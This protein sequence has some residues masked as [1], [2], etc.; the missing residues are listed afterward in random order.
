MPYEETPTIPQW[1]DALALPPSFEEYLSEKEKQKQE[2]GN[3]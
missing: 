2:E 1:D 3:D